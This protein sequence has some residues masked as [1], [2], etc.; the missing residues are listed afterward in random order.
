M[1]PIEE[2]EERTVSFP[3]EVRRAAVTAARAAADKKA[4]QVLVL[5]VGPMLGIAD[6]FIISSGSNDRQVRTI[7]EA[8]EDAL[9]EAH[10]KKPKRVEGMDDARWVL[11][12]FGD[13]VVH[14][15][16][17]EARAYYELERLWSDAV[18]LEWDG[19]IAQQA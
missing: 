5:D 9:R 4:E 10:G 13:L 17:G 18:R 1:S 2:R 11:L 14:V 19:A 6:A 12:D 15:F 7:A 16:N 8:V 3:E